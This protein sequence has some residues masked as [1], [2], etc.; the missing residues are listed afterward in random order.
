MKRTFV[1]PGRRREVSA[2]LKSGSKSMPTNSAS[3]IGGGEQAD[4]EA[5]TAAEV[6]VAIG[7]ASPPRLETP[8]HRT[9][10]SS[11]SGAICGKKFAG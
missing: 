6:R 1:R 10:K 11:Q 5:G 8:A 7:R 2:V 4:M 9:Q 3:R